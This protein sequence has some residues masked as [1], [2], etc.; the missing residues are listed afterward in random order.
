M[1]RLTAIIILLANFT[2]INAQDVYRNY[3]SA[4]L[5]KCEQL[6]PGLSILEKHALRVVRMTADEK[7]YQKVKAV[8]PDAIDVYYRTPLEKNEQDLVIDFGEHLTGSLHFRIESNIA[9]H[10]PVRLKIKFAEMPAEMYASFDQYEGTLSKVW[11][12]EEIITVHTLPAEIALPGRY[13]FRYLKFEILASA[14]D[15][16][17]YIR[18]VYC[19][20]VSSAGADLLTTSAQWDQT[21]QTISD[22]SIRTLRECMQTVFEDGPKR[23]RRI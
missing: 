4:W 7:A 14:G 10:A 1:K 12:Q 23:D 2:G 17:F 19:T 20:A 11:L 6:L 22:V 21:F 18:D 5:S 3:R 13:A 8:Q 9:A 15:M 16:D